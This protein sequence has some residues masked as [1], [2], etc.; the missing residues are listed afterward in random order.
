MRGQPPD[1]A[2]ELATRPV[3]PQARCDLDELAFPASVPAHIQTNH[4]P[5]HNPAS[6]GLASASGLCGGMLAL[7]HDTTRCMPVCQ[8]LPLDTQDRYL[9]FRARPPEVSGTL[10]PKLWKPLP[11]LP[12]LLRPFAGRLHTHRAVVEST[13]TSFVAD[14]D[15]GA[16]SGAPDAPASRLRSIVRGSARCDFWRQEKTLF[17]PVALAQSA[18][19]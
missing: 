7:Y 19:P 3:R 2:H 16:A 14:G 12:V 11:Q 6:V 18:R 5:P 4:S 15:G 1:Q 10:L 9:C 13:S 8:K 17:G